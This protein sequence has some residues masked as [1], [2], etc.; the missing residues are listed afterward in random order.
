MSAAPRPRGFDEIALHAVRAYRAD[1]WIL[2]GLAALPYLVF[3]LASELL[4]SPV[5]PV[6]DPLL[7]LRAGEALPPDLA[8]RF[9]TIAGPVGVVAAIG[10]AVAVLQSAAVI[11][12]LQTRRAGGVPTVGAALAGGLRAAPRLLGATLLGGAAALGASLA[13]AT[14]AALSGVDVIAASGI[15]AGGLLLG[16]LALTWSVVPFMTTVDRFE[17]RAAL[18]GAFELV[19]GARWRI[20]A[21]VALL[22]AVEFVV[23]TAAA[24]V[25]LVPLSVSAAAL[26]IGLQLV[27][28]AQAVFWVPLQWALLGELYVDLRQQQEA[29]ER[30]RAFAALP[31]RVE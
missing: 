20:L 19:R 5:R 21:L 28:F 13:L 8:Q 30:R 10:L 26:A 14:F 11:A 23:T 29:R 24:F 7:A 31:R 4:L 17:P 2:L 6:L 27:D 16:Y 12:A 3:A 15:A 18:R 1:V 9:G 22:V 25:V